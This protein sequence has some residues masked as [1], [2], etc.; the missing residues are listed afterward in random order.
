MADSPNK[1]KSGVVRCS[2]F[3]GGEAVG[4]AF[5]LVSVHVEKAVGRIGCAELLYRAGDMPS[6]S[7]PE[8]DDDTFA[9]GAK[10][11]IEA[12][13]GDDETPIFEG[14][15]ISHGVDIGNGNNGLLRIECRDYAFAMT[16]GRRSRV[17]VDSSDSDA[18]TAVLGGYSSLTATV[19]STATKYGELVQYYSTDWD[20]LRSLADR[21]GMV[22]IVEGENITIKKPDTGS[23]P[24]LTLTYGPDIMSFQADVSAEGQVANI[25]AS[26]WDSAQQ[27][28]VKGK[29]QKPSLNVQGSDD[30][31]TL[32]AVGG[33]KEWSL[34]TVAAA[35]ADALSAWADARRLRA[36]MARIRGKVT[37]SG[38]AKAVAG[39][40]VELD[41]FGKHF[42]GEAYAGTVEHTI[43]DGGWETVVHMGLPAEM[44]SSRHNT[45]APA[46][47]G[48]LPAVGGLHIGKMVKPDGD[49]AKNGRVQV[50]IPTLNGEN[51]VV[52]A[53]LASPWASKD[54]GSFMVP[55]AGDEV[56]VGFFNDDPCYPAVLGSLYSGS[57]KAPYELAAKNDI[58]ALVTR[59]K[60][61]MVFDDKD[62][63][64]TIETPGGN[65]LVI[66]D[67]DKGIALTDQN[68]NKLTM[69]NSGITLESSK[70]LN[71]KSGTET[72]VKAGS[73]AS[74]QASTDLKLKGLNVEMKAD[75][76]L[77]AQGTASSEFSASG[78]TTV[79]GAVVMI[80]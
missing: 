21:N 72:A 80:N 78:T 16:Q 68:G 75:V 9:I 24:V 76:S 3:S 71:I 37:F 79:K 4:A 20:F 36:G 35:D 28:S 64:F 42:N 51:N 5:R 19:A 63:S 77:K 46:A 32:G 17:F 14:V 60:I 70:A 38:S 25:G 56:I 66:S 22:A 49:P 41:G 2:V 54:Y 74:V 65:R 18:M 23:E 39:A 12:G 26:A 1:D 62:K 33:M 10:V 53:R 11:R 52:W 31:A 8:S 29:S 30:A 45:T 58:H 50:E 69:N 47:S 57:R 73:A 55:D 7:V 40:M 43:R 13:Y 59:E 34:Q 44:T 61:R 27:K 67:K 6:A 15:V 48:L